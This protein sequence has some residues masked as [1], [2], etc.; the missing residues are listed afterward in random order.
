[1]TFAKDNHS[2]LSC[3]QRQNV[4]PSRLFS[5]QIHVIKNIRTHVKLLKFYC[6]EINITI[7]FNYIINLLKTYLKLFL[8]F[9]RLNVFLF[10]NDA[11]K[12]T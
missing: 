1:M 9:L 11:S 8:H 4:Q 6:M 3:C 5:T 10:S 7:F 12:K 2:F